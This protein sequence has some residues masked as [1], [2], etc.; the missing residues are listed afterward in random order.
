MRMMRKDRKT[1]RCHVGRMW[2]RRLSEIRVDVDDVG[3]G[4][5][6]NWLKPPS[7]DVPV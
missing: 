7:I 2:E 3:G 6:V 4:V 1:E 5:T